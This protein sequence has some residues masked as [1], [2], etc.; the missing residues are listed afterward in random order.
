MK[1]LTLIRHV[2]PV[3][4]AVLTV[5][6]AS[7]QNTPGSSVS[8]YGV[9]DACLVSH[10]SERGSKMQVNGGG[11]F[12]GSRFGLRG[13]E[14]LGAGLRATFAL[15]SGFAIDTGAS[16]QGGRLF[17]RRSTV[18]LTGGFG[19]VELGREL[20]PPHFLISSIDPMQLGI[21]S[22]SATL[23]T[24]SPG[25]SSGRT[26]NSVIYVT[27][28]FGGFVARMQLAPGEQTAPLAQRGGDTKGLSLTY[29]DKNLLAGAAHATV[30][31]P[32]ATQTDRAT[33]A[34]AKYDFGSF[35]LAALAQFGA[36]EGT[37]TAAAPSS[38][39]ALYSRDYRSYVVGGTLK[40]GA[41]SL[42]AT[43]KRY[44]DRTTSNF[45]ATVM[46]AVYIHPLSKRTQ[47]YTGISRL[48]NLRASSY[49][50][51]DGNGAY[52][53]TGVGG[54]SR[55]LDLGITHFF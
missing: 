50:A 35:S 30:R 43:Y 32:A 6:G 10:S 22:A 42:S 54:S 2:A 11:C 39:T 33:T 47:I 25:T 4:G 19:S 23:W 45:D 36:W 24:G 48:K 41:N 12:Y 28:D 49:G 55:I 40:L 15:E 18:G 20:P 16:G 8:L 13:S 17:G 14:D 51:A 46:S 9:V 5:G 26:D 53:G 29:R 7:A 38:A 34:G 37:R 31:N 21:G 44:D 3:L 52:A 27:P 1:P